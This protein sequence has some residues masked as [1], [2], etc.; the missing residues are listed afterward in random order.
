MHVFAVV[1][2]A[3]NIASWVGQDCTVGVFLSGGVFTVV[4]VLI[5]GEGT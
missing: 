4:E 5:R 2:C 3:A 1:Y